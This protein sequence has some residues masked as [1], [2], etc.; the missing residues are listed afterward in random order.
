MA[1]RGDSIFSPL[2]GEVAIDMAR[3]QGKE[4]KTFLD[5]ESIWLPF[6]NSYDTDLCNKRKRRLDS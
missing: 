1:A 5:D 2:F 6:F 4:K 3:T